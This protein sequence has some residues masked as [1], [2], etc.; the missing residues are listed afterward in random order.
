MLFQSISLDASMTVSDALARLAIYG[1]WLDP[2]HPAARPRIAKL[3][4][5][6]GISFETAAKRLARPPENFGAASRR[7]L[8][9]NILW[10]ARP[11]ATVLEKCV[12]AD[13]ASDLRSALGLQETDSTG[14]LPVSEGTPT[15]E[16][17]LFHGGQPVAIN[18]VPTGAQ[19]LR[20]AET[21]YPG[22]GSFPGEPW[23]TETLPG[24]ATR[25]PKSRGF[26]FIDL[27][28]PAE[29]PAP[30]AELVTWPRLDAPEYVPAQQPFEVVVGF[31]E[32]QQKGV[33]GGQLS[34]PVPPDAE[35]IEVTV[36]L[37]ADG[38]DAP[39]GWSKVLQVPVKAPASVQVSFRLTG[40]DFVGT[41]PVQLTTLEVRYLVRGTVCG[42][43]ARP[44]AI[45][46][47]AA[48]PPPSVSQGTS[49]LAQP[50]TASTMTLKADDLAPDL[51]IE[52]V[53]PDR[54]PTGGRYLCR[55]YSP[56]PITANKGPHQVDLGKDA[57]S[58]AKEVV[59]EI[60]E[61]GRTPLA[62]NT[63]MSFADLVAGRLPRAA[64]DA[65]REVAT[66]VAPEPPA[67]LIVSADPY[68][69]WELARINP[70]LDPSRPPFLGAQAIVGRWLREG[71]DAGA[72]SQPAPSATPGAS[73]A[74]NP[75]LQPL[76]RMAVRYM[77]VMAGMYQAESGLQ[78]LPSAEAEAR[79]LVELYHALPLAATAQAMNQLLYAKLEYDFKAIGGVEAVHFA[80]H[81]DFDP[82]RPDASAL[83]LS[84]GCPLRSSLFR[85]AQYGGAR[86]PLI[87]INACMIG[88][89]DELLGD[90]GGFP[91][92]CLRGGFGGVL[93]AL[94]EVDDSVAHDIAIEF[95]RRALPVDGKK[96]ESVGAI[97]RDVRSR[98]VANQAPA[99]VTTYLSY[100]F[101]G[102]PRLT[103]Q[104]VTP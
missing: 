1:L 66:L 33:L 52:L 72:A 93:G 96:P 43:A 91:G 45:G 12:N 82:Q 87:F 63:L 99:P 100:V 49:W 28:G 20:G 50:A 48:A 25:K 10:Y 27:G 84:D 8:Y 18:L 75:A 32:T 37:T 70:P 85:S 101:Y 81:G 55:L 59:D 3:A 26:G 34:V 77:A 24:Q 11:A 7:Q 57:K 2:Q 21:G 60:R 22:A 80:G 61:Y 14:V 65:L 95:W 46:H 30:A 42:T 89:G 5:I 51:T 74:E 73:Q 94:W 19:G 71:D 29:E 35:T 16:G 97:L 68:A 76:A 67:V 78:P 92:N 90:M 41:E 38:L 23:P 31:G 40:R 103:L 64:L 62:D 104:L 98:Y 53:K 88:I 6:L 15:R 36:E 54:D 9:T 102:H 56:H 83:F 17:V 44:L 69:P 13:P 39:D 47:P 79:T 86:Q 58:F 4:E